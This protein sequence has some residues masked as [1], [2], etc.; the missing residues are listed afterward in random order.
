MAGSE[1]AGI[2]AA[3]GD[4]FEGAACI[5]TND[6]EVP[7]SLTQAIQEFWQALGCHTTWLDSSDHDALVA[8]ISHLPH[9]LA[10]AAARTCLLH[11]A[12]GSLGGGGLRDTTRVAS[13]NVE[14]WT[15]ILLENREALMAPLQESIDDL[16][17]LQN[18]LK[19]GDQDATRQWLGTAKDRRDSINPER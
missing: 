10:A 17:Q 19:A 14:M 12:D 5:L 6:Q 2:Q 15:E 13:G 7:D 1:Q 9:A 3:H 18:A 16:I 11:P 4:L 8:R